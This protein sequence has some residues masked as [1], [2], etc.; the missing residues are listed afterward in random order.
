MRVCLGVPDEVLSID[1]LVKD[2]EEACPYEI[3]DINGKVNRAVEWAQD[4][5]WV[6]P[7]RPANATLPDSVPP[8]MASEYWDT[9]NKLRVR[10]AARDTF[11]LEK[12]ES[13]ARRVRFGD[14][15]DGER[16]AATRPDTPRWLVQGLIHHGGSV[17]LAA[18]YKAGK[19]TLMLNLVKSLTTGTDFLGEFSVPNALKVAYVDMELGYAMA[20]DWFNDIPGVDYKNMVYFPRVGLGG[21]MNFKSETIRAKWARVLRTNQV[22]LLIVDPLSPVMS[23]LGID[24]NSAETVRPLLDSF[25]QLKVEA[26]LQGVVVTHHTG[27]QNTGRA[28]GST[29][30]ND[31]PTSIMSVTKQGEDEQSER[32]FRAFGR[33]VAVPTTSLMFDKPTRTLKLSSAVYKQGPPPI[34]DEW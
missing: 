28:R 19:S 12:V 16:F 17:L 15:V 33:D 5:I 13:E 27:H 18:Q 7:P 34:K 20:W 32:A 10:E 1:Q 3:K 30:F 4:R 6:Q 2:F 22:D 31:W 9:L 23:A 21:Q 29:A 26:N 24:E 8:E 14:Y 25:D 11:T